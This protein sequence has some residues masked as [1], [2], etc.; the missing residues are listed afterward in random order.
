MGWAVCCST[1][2]LIKYAEIVADVGQSDPQREGV[3]AI[4]RMAGDRESEEAAGPS[5]GGSCW[6]R[7]MPRLK[8]L[9]RYR[10]VTDAHS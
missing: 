9:A 6:R 2:Y 1:P 10:A 3:I 4:E 8:G 5:L 7:A